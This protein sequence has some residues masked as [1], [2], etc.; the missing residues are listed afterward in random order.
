MD[1]KRLKDLVDI[2]VAEVLACRHDI[3][4]GT[5][6][7]QLIDLSQKLDIINQRLE[8]LERIQTDKVEIIVPVVQL[9]NNQYYTFPKKR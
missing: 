2:K 6:Q 1:E 8:E 9:I 7:K 3:S 5:Y 4:N